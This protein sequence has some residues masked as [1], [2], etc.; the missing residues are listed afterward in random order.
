VGSVNDMP[1]FE[2]IDDD[3]CAAWQRLTA[4]LEKEGISLPGKPSPRS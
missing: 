4:E 1:R 2:S 3:A